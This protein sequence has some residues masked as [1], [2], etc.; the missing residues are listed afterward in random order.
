[1]LLANDDASLDRRNRIHLFVKESVVK[2]KYGDFGIFGKG[3]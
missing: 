3:R 2:I 1:M